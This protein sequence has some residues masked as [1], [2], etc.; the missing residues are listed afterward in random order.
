[1][2]S[3]HAVSGPKFL[4]SVEQKRYSV[5]GCCRLNILDKASIIVCGCAG[6]S[7]VNVSWRAANTAR[8]LPMPKQPHIGE[9]SAICYV[10]EMDHMFMSAGL[11][12][13]VRLWR[14]GCQEACMVEPFHH[15]STCLS[16]CAHKPSVFAVR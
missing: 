13:R 10:P 12:G 1:M 3:C 8:A 14:S 16:I 6:E 2:W 9:V 7:R 5:L 11:D 4:E 15:G